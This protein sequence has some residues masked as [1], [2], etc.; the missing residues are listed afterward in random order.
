VFCLDR[1]KK[2][3]KVCG[4]AGKFFILKVFAELVSA[5]FGPFVLSRII[6][7]VFSST[8]RVI[9]IVP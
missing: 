2:E 1:Q 3:K 8:L 7:E 6:Q 5:W 4:R 9:V